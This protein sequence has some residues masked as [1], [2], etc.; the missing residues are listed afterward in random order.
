MSPKL[1]FSDE[2][3]DARIAESDGDV[4]SEASPLDETPAIASAPV[5]PV[6]EPAVETPAEEAERLL[7]NKYKTP[8]DLERGYTELQ[9]LMGR[10]EQEHQAQLTQASQLFEQLMY[11]QQPAAPSFVGQPETV[12]DLRDLAQTSPDR[13]FDFAAGHPQSDELVPLVVASVRAYNEA[14]ADAYMARHIRNTVQ[15]E[16][17]A[18]KRELAPMQRASSLQS[19]MPHFA[20]NFPD[21]KDIEQDLVQIAAGRQHMLG[22]DPTAADFYHLLEDSYWIAK[23]Y[24][25]RQAAAAPV[26]APVVTAPFVETGTPGSAPEPEDSTVEDEIKARIMKANKSRNPWAAFTH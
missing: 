17:G 13:A 3:L 21:H 12:D 8:E 18:V 15:K 19:V 25:A 14:A 20:Q 10:K 6:V 23:G 7:A 1:D 22:T 24:Q 16:V 11:Q 4:S 2:G 9:Q 5:E 26:V